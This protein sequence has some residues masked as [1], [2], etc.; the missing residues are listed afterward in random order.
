MSLS[1]LE[2]LTRL[3]AHFMGPIAKTLINRE[4]RSV[5]SI[6]ALCEVLAREID[7][8]DER[9]RFLRESSQI[10]KER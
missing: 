1:D 9:E 5:A 10:R 8:R 2:A 7:D 6:Q 4:V 3:F